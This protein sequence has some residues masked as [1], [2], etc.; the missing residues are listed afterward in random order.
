[1]GDVANDESVATVGGSSAPGLDRPADAADS[2]ARDTCCAPERR[3]HNIDKEGEG[4]IPM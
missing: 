1:M 3:R 2:S 4:V